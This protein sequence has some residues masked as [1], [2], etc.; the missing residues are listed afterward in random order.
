M[1]DLKSSVDRPV[2]E[3]KGFR[4]VNLAPGETKDVTF[5]LT[6]PDLSYFD[7]EKH[8]WVCEPGAFEAL[9][10]ASSGDIRS[11]VRFNIK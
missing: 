3:L 2:K 4:K 9:V 11:K 7:A 10:G 1:A 5:T 6:R 8:E